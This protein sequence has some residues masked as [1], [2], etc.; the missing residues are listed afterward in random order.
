MS[1]HE[2][3]DPTIL[4]RILDRLR[5][6]TWIVNGP[7]YAALLTEHEAVAAYVNRLLDNSDPGSD[8]EDLYRAVITA[9]NAATE[10][11]T[12]AKETPDAK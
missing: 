1:V 12:Q 3:L 10:V 6:P 9:H 4:H 7:D 2:T 8:I 11:L 5:S